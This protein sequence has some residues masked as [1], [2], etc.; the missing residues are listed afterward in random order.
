MKVRI[1]KPVFG[2]KV[3]QIIDINTNENGIP[4]AIYWRRRLK[5]AEIDNC[6]EVIEEKPQKKLE[7]SKSEVK[8]KKIQ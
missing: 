1:N 8:R 2:H 4:T 3:G 5:D 7:P 6:I